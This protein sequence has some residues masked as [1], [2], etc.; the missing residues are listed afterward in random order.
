ME[1][2]LAQS[3]ADSQWPVSVSYCCSANLKIFCNNLRGRLSWFIS[4][5]IKV[6]IANF[7]AHPGMFRG[8]K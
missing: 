8:K 5:E 6:W 1:K 3:L 2:S 4:E 7:L